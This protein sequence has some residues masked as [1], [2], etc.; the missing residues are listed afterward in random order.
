MPPT[1]Q[2][3]SVIDIGVELPPA[4]IPHCPERIIG[5]PVRHGLGGGECADQCP[6]ELKRNSW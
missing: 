2:V 4:E 6:S 3:Q 5:L 1:Q